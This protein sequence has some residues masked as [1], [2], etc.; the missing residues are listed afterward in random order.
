MFVGI[1]WVVQR[2]VLDGTEANRTTFRLFPVSLQT[3]EGQAADDKAGVDLRVGRLRQNAVGELGALVLW[4]PLVY[5]HQQ[6]VVAI[7]Q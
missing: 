2:S 7:V 3:G 1:A 4:L 6:G 5:H